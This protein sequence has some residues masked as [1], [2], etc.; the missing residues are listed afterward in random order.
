M[1]HEQIVKLIS[2]GTFPEITGQRQLV[3]TH[4]SWVI[5]CDE[6]VYKIKKPIKYSF[7]DFCTLERR[8]YYCQRELELNQRFAKDI[9]LDV[10]PIQKA[11]GSFKIGANKGTPIDYA[12]KMRKLDPERRLDKLL[13][14]DK[15]RTEHII[16]LAL[17]IA[18]FHKKSPIIHKKNVFD[19]KEKFNDLAAEKN[20]VSEHL[21][22]AYAKIIDRAIETSDKFLHKNETL[23]KDRLKAGFSRDCH[24]D[25]HTRNIFMLPA[26]QPFDCLEFNDDYRHI[27]VLNEVAFL[28]MDLDAF[29]KYALS[30]LCIR[31]YN[32]HFP[33]MR[34]EEERQLFV[35]YKAYRANVRAKVNSIR[36]RSE[37]DE[38]KKQK[39]QAETSKYL[40]IMEGYLQSLH[41]D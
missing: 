19:V 3:E 20:F 37:L 17:W 22:V 2:E 26:P 5:L 32:L 15:V 30:D 29:E 25:L 41:I 28:C 34:T 21:G 13:K 16:N 6:F 40:G 1:T 39:A 14:K 18:N 33:T 8:K 23:L 4:I 35:Y 27:D 7:L 38:I 9:Y 11:N 10:L 31:H 36:T 24:G 12:L